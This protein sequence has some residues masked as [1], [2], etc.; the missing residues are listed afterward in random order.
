MKTA[1]IYFYL[2]SQVVPSFV[3]FSPTPT[4]ASVFLIKS[5]I[6]QFLS[7][8]AWFLTFRIFSRT[9]FG[10]STPVKKSNSSNIEVIFSYRVLSSISI[11]EKYPLALRNDKYLMN[12]TL[13]LLEKDK[14]NREVNN[15]IDIS[16]IDS[17]YLKLFLN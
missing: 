13:E 7:T 8:R 12:T 15:L 9:S 4:F 17:L 3:S 10:S 16:D 2:I 1:L 5:A 6:S 14:Y 11:L